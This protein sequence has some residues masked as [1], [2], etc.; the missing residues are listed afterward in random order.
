[1]LNVENAK[2]V[3]AVVSDVNFNFDSL[4]VD[5]VALSDKKLIPGTDTITQNVLVARQEFDNRI[6]AWL[7]GVHEICSYKTA[8]DVLDIDRCSAT[9]MPALPILVLPV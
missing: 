6:T 1:M 7:S 3:E 2:I 4:M 9:L 5:C 8:C